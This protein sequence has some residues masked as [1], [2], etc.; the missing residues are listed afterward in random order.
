MVITNQRKIPTLYYH[1]MLHILTTMGIKYQ[2]LFKQQLTVANN[3]DTLGPPSR[4]VKAM[5]ILYEIV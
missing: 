2:N 3:N 5:L 4:S 1:N